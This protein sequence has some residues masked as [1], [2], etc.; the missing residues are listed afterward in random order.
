MLLAI[1]GGTDAVLQVLITRRHYHPERYRLPMWMYD[2]SRSFYLWGRR[3]S[4][5]RLDDAFHQV[6]GWRF[7]FNAS[8]WFLAGAAAWGGLQ[9]GMGLALYWWATR[10]VIFHVV[11][12]R[13]GWR[14]IPIIRFTERLRRIRY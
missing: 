4:L 8:A 11:L 13:K 9:V 2:G 3:R 7:A 6:Q 10:E 14:Q 1:A 5:H 12:P